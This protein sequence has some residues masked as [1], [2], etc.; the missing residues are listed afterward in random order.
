MG[1]RK[2]TDAG[3]VAVIVVMTV[4]MVVVMIV[5]MVVMV[6]AMVMVVVI[7]RVRLAEP[8]AHVGGLGRRI[9]EPALQ[10]LGDRSP[11]DC[12][13][14]SARIDAGDPRFEGNKPFR[15]VDQVE[16]GRASCREGVL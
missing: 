13:D 5:A 9:V 3:I 12:A 11:F 14:F 16:I 7:M 8:A 15:V 10:Q 4:I 2:R 6:V 1:Q